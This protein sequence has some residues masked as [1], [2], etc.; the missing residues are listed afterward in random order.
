MSGYESD[1]AVFE[2]QLMTW[3]KIMQP[4]YDAHI[5][6]LACR[7]NHEAASV[8]S[9]K[10]WRKVFSGRYAMPNNGPAN[11]K[12]LTFFYGKAN[13][14]VIGLDQYTFGKEMVNQPWLDGLLRAYPK[15]FIFAMG[16]EPAFMDGSHKD[17]M[18]ANAAARDAFWESLIRSGSRVFFAGHDHLYDHMV[19]VRDGPNPGPEM[20]QIV[21]GTSGAPFYNVGEY[22][23]KN[24]GWKLKRVKHI[25]HTYGYMLVEIDGRRATITFKGRVAPNKYAAMDS[26]SYT[27]PAR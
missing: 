23:G 25:D 3:R 2:T 27:V 18:D 21:A 26:F 6:I 10:V 11:E 24:G 16:H 17:T 19:V 22:A 12:G 13:V 9:D 7:G 8:D 15:P 1:T 4:V 14:L 5:P 20:H